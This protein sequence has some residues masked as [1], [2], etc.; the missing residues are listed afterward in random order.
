MPL[1]KFHLIPFR[2]SVAKDNI[3][4][5]IGECIMYDTWCTSKGYRKQQGGKFSFY[6]TTSLSVLCPP[7]L[8]NK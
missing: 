5:N 8:E 2:K 3:G 4:R 1:G 7:R 6:I